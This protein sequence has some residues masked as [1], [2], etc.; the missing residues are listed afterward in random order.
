MAKSVSGVSCRS[1]HDPHSPSITSP[2]Q[3]LHSH[4]RRCVWLVMMT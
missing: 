2:L 1:P 4:S 3:L